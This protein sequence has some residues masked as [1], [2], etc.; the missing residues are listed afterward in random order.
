MGEGIEMPRY[1]KIAVD[2]ASKVYKGQYLEGEKLR[3]RSILA[4]E[5]NVSPETIRKSMKL[6]E[7]KGVVEVNKGSGILIKSPDKAYRF[8]ESFKEKESIGM[9]RSSMKRLLEDR[10]NIERQIQEV[11]EK[12]IDYSYR[13]KSTNLIEPI[14]IEVPEKSH[15]LGKTIGESE[16]WHNTGGTIIGVK[17]EEEILISPGPYLEFKKGDKILVVGDEGLSQR[18]KRYLEYE[19]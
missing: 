4:G 15:I 10:K 19:E 6:L 18:I 17:R 13:F 12:I 16:F 2:V 7:D 8:M 1:V 3:G 11:N 9:L 14:E 5:Y